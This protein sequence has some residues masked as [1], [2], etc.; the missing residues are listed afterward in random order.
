MFH[1]KQAAARWLREDSERA[2]KAV[3]AYF[4]RALRVKMSKAGRTTLREESA[5]RQ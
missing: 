5:H 3:R 1:V 4:E 2:T